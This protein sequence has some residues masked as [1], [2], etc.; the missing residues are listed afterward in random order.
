MKSIESGVERI[1][2]TEAKACGL[3]ILED[4]DLQSLGRQ[5][6]TWKALGPGRSMTFQQFIEVQKPRLSN[7]WVYICNR[8]SKLLGGKYV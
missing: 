7:D 3:C 6:L 5:Y 1:G 4:P 2:D 8:S